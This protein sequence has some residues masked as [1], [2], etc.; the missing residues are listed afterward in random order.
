MGHGGGRVPMRPAR[1]TIA[2]IESP[3]ADR[4]DKGLGAA[5]VPGLPVERYG[6]TWRIEID[7]TVMQRV[8]DG[9]PP[10]RMAGRLGYDKTTGEAPAWDEQAERFVPTR[11]HDGD[12]VPFLVR[13]S[14]LSVAFQRTAKIRR[15]SFIGALQLLLREGAQSEAW[16]VVDRTTSRTWAE[17]ERAVEKVTRVRIVI[18]PTNPGWRGQELFEPYIEDMGGDEAVITIKGDDLDLDSDPIAQARTHAIQHDYGELE[19][20]GVTADGAQVAF[21]SGDPV[22]IVDI[23]VTRDTDGSVDYSALNDALNRMDERD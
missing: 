17:F 20:K 15:Q 22:P 3:Y 6:R 1:V 23:D 19:V 9:D 12:V 2:R 16:S 4:T 11:Q 5:L 10:N 8:R 14:D 7:P 13:L 21:D 18:G